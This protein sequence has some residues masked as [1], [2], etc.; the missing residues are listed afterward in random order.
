MS[1]L[2]PELVFYLL[3]LFRGELF[4]PLSAKIAPEGEL[5][6]VRWVTP[7]EGAAVDSLAD[8]VAFRAVPV[9]TLFTEMSGTI[10]VPDG[11]RAAVAAFV[12]YIGVS[13]LLAVCLAGALAHLFAERANKILRFSLFLALNFLGALSTASI[14]GNFALEAL[15]EGKLPEGISFL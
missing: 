8:L 14:V 2:S 9:V 5:C 15:E 10:A 11:H 7:L 6:P 12:L 4:N 13:V 3:D 1:F